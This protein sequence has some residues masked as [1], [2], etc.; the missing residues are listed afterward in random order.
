MPFALTVMYKKN[1]EQSVCIQLMLYKQ[2]PVIRGNMIINHTPIECQN[3][4]NTFLLH[5]GMM[6]RLRSDRR[7]VGTTHRFPEDMRRF[8]FY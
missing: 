7:L 4:T 6:L 2:S 1:N 5:V 8:P 3:I